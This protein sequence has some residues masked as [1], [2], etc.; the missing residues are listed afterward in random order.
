MS[1]V[2]QR[3]DGSEPDK[4]V[5]K[6][7]RS[8]WFLLAVVVLHIGVSQT[9]PALS[10]ESLGYFLKVMKH[11]I[12]AFGII[13]LLLWLF[14]L[15]VRPKQIRGWLGKQ[16]GSKG[17]MFSI[18]AGVL[19]MGRMYLWYP[20]LGDLKKQGMR[21]SLLTAFLYSRAVKI[22]MLPFM[23]HYFG[24]LYSALFV[25]NVLI[26]SFLSGIIMERVCPSSR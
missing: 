12:P 19:T 1:S 21:T 6:N 17:W 9:N 8:W 16:S 14:N 13:F 26:F 25:L 7:H 3:R 20:L 5:R 23:V 10:E 18:L 11:L 4:K 24:S 2:N 22:P 15:F